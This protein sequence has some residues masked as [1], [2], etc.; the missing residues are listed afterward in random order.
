MPA[1]IDPTVTMMQVEEKP[2]IT[3]A[4]VGGCK[5]QIEK[6]REVVEMPLL[7]VI[8]QK[9][10]KFKVILA[11]T[12][13]RHWDWTTQ[14][15]VVLRSTGYWQNTLRSCS[16]QS[17]GCLFCNFKKNDQTKRNN[18]HSIQIRVIGSEL[19]QKYVG[20]GARMVRELFEMAKSKKACIIFF[21]FYFSNIN[22]NFSIL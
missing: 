8:Q 18:F 6:L 14:R 9:N 15:S 19:V 3:Y 11:R 7:H 17:H 2:D 21:G 10:N 16:G 13:C 1:K 4:D 12:L 22:S 5:E 20:E